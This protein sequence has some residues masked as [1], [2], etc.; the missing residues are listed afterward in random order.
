M[1]TTSELVRIVAETV[2]RKRLRK[3]LSKVFQ[4]LRIAVNGELEALKKG[5]KTAISFLL[6]EARIVV[7]SYHSLEDRI[8]KYTFKEYA[9]REV[10]SI[11]TQK[12][13]RPKEEEIRDN[14][15]IRSAKLRSGER[16]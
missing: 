2:P 11:L 16:R 1:R 10:I 13:L 4:A 5:L 7:L 9:A 12:P 8:V 15:R 14:P 3:S 6:P